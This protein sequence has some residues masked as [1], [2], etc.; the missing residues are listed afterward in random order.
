M[1]RSDTRRLAFI[2]YQQPRRAD[3]ANVARAQRR[4]NKAFFDTRSPSI[5]PSQ[6]GVASE[7]LIV[8]FRKENGR[9]SPSWL[10]LSTGRSTERRSW[11]TSSNACHRRSAKGPGV[12][13][14]IEGTTSQLP[15]SSPDL[16]PIEMPF[17]KFKAFLRGV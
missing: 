3:R 7:R 16:N 17:S 10:W 8:T 4:G 15:Q 6:R 9:Q 5:G 14:A 12:K 13:A 1:Q 11:P 2:D